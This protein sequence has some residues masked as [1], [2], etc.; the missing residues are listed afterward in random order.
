[1]IA[2]FKQ[3]SP[4]NIVLLFIVG[5]L[6]KMPLFLQPEN[7]TATAED[8]KLYTFLISFI[9]NA[10][11]NGFAGAALAFL[12]VYSQAL[13]VNS[14]VNEQRMTSRQSYLPA[15]AYLLITSLL[16]EW[17]YLSASLVSSTLIIWAFIKLFRLYNVASAYASIYNIG[18]I[19][20]IS[21]FIFFPSSAFILCLLFGIMVLRPF[22]FNELILLLVGLI[23]PYYF[24]AVYLYLT[25]GFVYANLLP[26][27]VFRVPGFKSTGVFIGVIISLVLPFI[28]GIYQV[29]THLRKMVIQVRKNWV[30]LLL[31]LILAMLIPFI[32]NA[33]LLDNW[34]LA[35]PAFAAFHCCAYLYPKK[36]TI[37]IDIIFFN[38]RFYTFSAIWFAAMETV[39]PFKKYLCPLKSIL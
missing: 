38:S 19:V 13:M 23:T 33:S 37:G 39:N 2:L 1:M 32:N 35:L 17:M 11:N 34:V 9:G 30:I 14:L 29:Q 10:E 22:Q 5:L 26:K 24:Y 27:F 4:A 28:I 20:G 18:L 8:G 3:K 31:Y 12:L 15:M 21:S 16:P 25:D 6:L 7:I 36:N